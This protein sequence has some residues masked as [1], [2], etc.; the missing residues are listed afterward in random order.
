MVMTPANWLDDNSDHIA[1]EL[2]ADPAAVRRILGE[3]LTLKVRADGQV[4]GRGKGIMRMAEAAVALIGLI[5][6]N[7]NDD[8]TRVRALLSEPGYAI[9]AG[10][11]L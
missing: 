4:T 1:A 9:V 6:G 5:G 3:C 10:G 11:E 7:V 2:G 8:Y